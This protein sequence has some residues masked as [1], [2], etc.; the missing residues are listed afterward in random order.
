VSLVR[1]HFTANSKL[2]NNKSTKSTI[3]TRLML[4]VCIRRLLYTHSHVDVSISYTH[5]HYGGRMVGLK[6]WVGIVHTG[7][8]TS[9]T[10]F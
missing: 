5:T 8:L 1:R 6:T 10:S 3:I 7:S 4:V 9:L 2:G